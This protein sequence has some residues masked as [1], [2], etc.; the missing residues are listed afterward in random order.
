[1]K[2]LVV[3]LWWVSGVVC[4]IYSDCSFFRFCCFVGVWKCLVS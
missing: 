2:I 4:F 1:M 3:V